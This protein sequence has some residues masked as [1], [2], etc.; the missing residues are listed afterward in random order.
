MH[1]LHFMRTYCQGQVQEWVCPACNRKV[2]I[3]FFPHFERNVIVPGNTGF[4]HT[5]EVNGIEITGIDSPGG[6]KL[7]NDMGWRAFL[8]KNQITWTDRV[9]DGNP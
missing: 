1:V 9:K 2:M 6:P 4:T 8:V 3:R 7:G 5:A